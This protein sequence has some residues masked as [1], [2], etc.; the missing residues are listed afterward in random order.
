MLEGEGELTLQDES[1]ITLKEGDFYKIPLEKV[2]SFSTLD[3]EARA[4]VFRLHK[5]GQPDRILIE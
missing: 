3:T 2:H 5:S 4:V 1:A